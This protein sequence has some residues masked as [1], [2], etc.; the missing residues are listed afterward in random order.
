VFAQDVRLALGSRCRELILPLLALKVQGDAGLLERPAGG[1]EALL[2][3]E[4]EGELEGEAKLQLEEF[5]AAL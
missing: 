1:S 4:L 2:V 5:V 3:G